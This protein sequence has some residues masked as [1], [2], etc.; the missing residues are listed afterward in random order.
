MVHYIL[1]LSPLM[2]IHITGFNLAYAFLEQKEPNISMVW[3]L[4]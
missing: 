1:L 2:V 3:E 4:E